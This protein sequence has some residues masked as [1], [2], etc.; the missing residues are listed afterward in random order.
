MGGD[1]GLLPAAARPARRGRA[2][3][4]VADAGAVRPARGA[5]ASPSASSSSCEGAQRDPPA[6]RRRPARRRAGGAR[7]RGG[8]LVG[9]LQWAL[10]RLRSS[11][12]RPAR[13]AGPRTPSGPPPRPTRSCRCWR[14]TPA[15]AS[16]C[17]SGVP[18]TAGASA[19]RWPGASGCRS[20][21]TR[22]GSSAPCEDAGVSAVCVELTSR[23]GLGADEHLRPIATE[24]GVLL[25]PVDRADDVARVE[26]AG[27]SRRRPLPRLPPPHGPPPQALEQRRGRLRPR[28]RGRARPT[29]TR[30][31]SWRA[32]SS[33]WAARPLAGRAARRVAAVRAGHGAARALVVRGH[34]WLGAVVE[35]CA[36]TGA[37]AGPAR[38][39]ASQRLRAGRARRRSAWA[40]S[41]RPAAG[42]AGGDLSTWSAPAVAEMAFAARAAELRTCSPPA[43]EP[44]TA[45]CASCWRC[46]PATGPSWSPRRSP[47]PMRA[48][49]FEGHLA[50]CGEALGHGTCDRAAGLRNL[51]VDAGSRRRSRRRPRAGYSQRIARG[52]LAHAGSRARTPLHD[53]VRR[54]GLS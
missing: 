48:S 54:H 33:G 17:E 18:P 13:G 51:A 45:R 40:M 29:R 16:R 36:R 7:R 10:E 47:R 2:A 30:P 11:G 27:L 4:A 23:F 12:R 20:A 6:R 8:T 22:P 21:P 15:C 24:S 19:T 5:R 1:G 35:E 28:G 14:P 34:H 39:C 44:A 37:G 53:G 32:R 41:R 52:R 43:R 42:A 26:R 31:T 9:R 38:R 49:A 3:D 25:V 46:S 50:P